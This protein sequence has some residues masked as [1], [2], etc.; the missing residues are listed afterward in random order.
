MQTVTLYAEDFKTVHNTLCELRSIQQRL[1]GV[2]WLVVS[3]RWREPS[4]IVT[5]GI[6]LLTGLAGLAWNY[7]G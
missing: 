1:T 7:L 5:N 6:M 4:L 2:I 3:V